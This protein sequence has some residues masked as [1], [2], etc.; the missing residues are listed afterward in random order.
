MEESLSLEKSKQNKFKET[1]KKI[2][3]DVKVRKLTVY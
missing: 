1:V 2:K 3:H